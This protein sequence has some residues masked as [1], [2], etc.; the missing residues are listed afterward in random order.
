MN[1]SMKGG[2]LLLLVGAMC[3]ATG[4]A[5]KH[6][7][8]EDVKHAIKLGLKDYGKAIYRKGIPY[9]VNDVVQTDAGATPTLI[10]SYS[11]PWF[12]VGLPNMYTLSM[13]DVSDLRRWFEASYN[14]IILKPKWIGNAL[15]MNAQVFYRSGSYQ[16]N[17]NF[18]FAVDEDSTLLLE[19]VKALME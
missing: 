3:I 17:F 2:L 16:L 19:L 10:K 14:G 4:Q 7:S 12:N 8:L 11:R 18:H 9:T 6:L 5:N 1:S 15:Q 13:S